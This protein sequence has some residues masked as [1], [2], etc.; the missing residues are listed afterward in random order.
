MLSSDPDERLERN[1]EVARTGRSAV[2]V[3]SAPS[4]RPWGSEAVWLGR[5]EANGVR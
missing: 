1:C 5:L 3:K 2:A 4:S